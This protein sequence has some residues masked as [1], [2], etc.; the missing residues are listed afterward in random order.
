MIDKPYTKNVECISRYIQA[1]ALA[2][3]IF[4]APQ[5]KVT[6][7]DPEMPYYYHNIIIDMDNTD[8]E[9]DRLRD[10]ISLL[11]C[12]TGISFFGKEKLQLILQVENLY[13]VK[14]L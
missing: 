11:N 5:G 14:E 2:H 9:K 3:R 6:Y 4:P 1:C 13:S 7:D 12:S 10:F 8:F